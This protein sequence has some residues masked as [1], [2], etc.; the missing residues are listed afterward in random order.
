MSRTLICH[1]CH[2]VLGSGAHQG[3]AIGKSRCTM[4]HSLL[5]KGG[6]AESESWRACPDGYLYNPDVEVIS[7]TGL[8]ETLDPSGFHPNVMRRSTPAGSSQSLAGVEN[9]S[10]TLV[11]R[12]N[13]NNPSLEP[14][15]NSNADQERLRRQAA[16][17]GARRKDTGQGRDNPQH[18]S[19]ESQG[20]LI[21]SSTDALLSGLPAHIMAQ[22]RDFRAANQQANEV[23]D[24]PDEPNIN[25][26]HLRSDNQLREQVE[27][28]LGGLREQIPSLAAAPTAHNNANKGQSTLGNYAYNSEEN[29]DR[30]EWVT[31]STGRRRLIPMT[32]QNVYARDRFDTGSIRYQTSVRADQNAFI[33]GNNEQYKLEYRCSPQS[34]RLFQVKVPINDRRTQHSG[35]T[36]QPSHR[37]E[38]RCSP[39]S[40]RIWQECVPITPPPVHR[41]THH[42]EWRIHPIS[43]ET[44]Q[45]EV[46]TP[47]DSN[48][49]GYSDSRYDM[50]PDLHSNRTAYNV[51]PIVRQN[52][53]T[54][55]VS[56]SQDQSSAQNP[57]EVTSIS[58]IDR[59]SN[60][61]Q[62]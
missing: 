51:S 10:Q 49:I 12:P 22:I 27:L 34:G 14:T 41:Q 31:D 48:M 45:V 20:N 29:V 18:L 5:C 30:Y 60:R 53:L 8:T 61:R 58:G 4:T 13:P 43:G 23:R 2:T 50:R 56:R 37:L 57:G 26:T 28:G 35:Y 17:E 59:G 11:N 38:Y 52:Q 42:L 15:L 3:S 54:P 9:V 46:P 7:Y 19:S 62:S 33:G 36:S 32:D 44:Y 25:I 24:R 6:I 16:G 21:Q 1:G 47:L 40:G 39:T 55:G